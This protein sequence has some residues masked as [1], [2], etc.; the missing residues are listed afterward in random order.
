MLLN[1]S[2]RETAPASTPS[3]G[4]QEACSYRPNG[5]HPKAGWVGWVQVSF[6]E[7][8]RAQCLEPF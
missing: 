5:D 2:P 1:D 3:K 7:E 4:A 6:V 8:A